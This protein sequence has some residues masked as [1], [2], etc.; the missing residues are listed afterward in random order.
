MIN[1]VE[2]IRKD[3]KEFLNEY[4]FTQD[5][6]DTI[7]NMNTVDDNDPVVQT[8]NDSLTIPA[9]ATSAYEYVNT[10]VENRC[11]VAS[12]TAV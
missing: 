10:Y 8:W 2:T 9:G 11:P 7:L 4:G 6:V 12:G 1:S 3:Y 5:F